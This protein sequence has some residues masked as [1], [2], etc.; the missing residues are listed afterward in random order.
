MKPHLVSQEGCGQWSVSN[1]T[2]LAVGPVGPGTRPTPTTSIARPWEPPLPFPSSTSAYKLAAESCCIVLNLHQ[3]ALQHAIH[4]FFPPDPKP[5]W[6]GH[7]LHHRS[8][9]LRPHTID[10]SEAKCTDRVEPLAPEQQ[11]PILRRIC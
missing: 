9:Q 10:R 6:A 2:S 7:E 1:H 4:C 5:C 11:I 8:V 3:L